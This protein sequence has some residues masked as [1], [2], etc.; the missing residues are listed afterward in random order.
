MKRF[1]ILSVLALLCGAALPVA[2]DEYGPDSYVQDGLII[3]LDGEYNAGR[4]ANGVPLDHDKTLLNWVDLVGNRV[5][6]NMASTT[7]PKVLPWEDKALHFTTSPDRNFKLCFP[8]LTL[9]WSAITFDMCSEE[10]TAKSSGTLFYTETSVGTG[11]FISTGSYFYQFFRPSPYSFLQRKVTAEPYA[12]QFVGIVDGKSFSAYDVREG[13]QSQTPSSATVLGPLAA[14]F[15]VAG[16]SSSA[17]FKGRLHAFRVYERALSKK[18]AA[19]NEAV[20][21]VRYLGDAGNS[22]RVLTDQLPAAYGLTLAPA[23]GTVYANGATVDFGVT[24]LSAHADD[25]MLSREY[26]AGTRAAFYKW[27]AWTGGPSASPHSESVT[28]TTLSGSFTAKT[29]LAGVDWDIRAQH[30]V[31]VS[32]ATGGSVSVDGG[33]AEASFAGWFDEGAVV[34]LVAT[35]AEGF[36]FRRWNGD[37]GSAES[38]DPATITVPITSARKI[39]A[40]FAKP[41]ELVVPDAYGPDS[42]VQDGLIVQLD[43]E[44]NAG[45]NWSGGVLPHDGTL[46]CWMDLVCNRMLTNTVSKTANL[47][48]EDNAL[49]FKAEDNTVKLNFPSLTLDWSAITFDMCCEEDTAKSNGYLFLAKTSLG[50][51]Y[52][53]F[54]GGH[55]FR[56][57]VPSY[58]YLYRSSTAEPYVGQFF[59]VV[60]GKS[61]SAYDVRQGWQHSTPAAPTVL[62]TLT[63]DFFVGGN[64][65]G[66]TKF[67]G[68]YHAFRTY[69]RVLSEKE[70]AWNEAVDKVRYLGVAANSVKVIVD[71]LPAAYG[72]TLTPADGT[73]YTDGTTVDFSVEGLS[74]HADDGVLSREYET[75]SRAAFY[76]WTVWTGGPATS[77]HSEIATGMTLSDSLTAKNL[78]ANV[79]WDIRT[80]HKVDVSASGSG[81]VSVNGG[82]AAASFSGWFDEGSAVTL[83]ATPVAGYEFLYWIGDIGS[84]SSTEPSIV[85]EVSAAR[86]VQAVFSAPHEP[87]RTVWTGGSSTEWDNPAN[88]D[89]GVPQTGDDVVITNQGSARI[90]LSHTTPVFNSLFVQNGKETPD[91]SKTQ[92]LVLTNWT[93]CLRAKTITLG[94]GA[95][96]KPMG[97]CYN[98]TMPSRVWIA[99]ETLTV[100]ETAKIDADLCGYKSKGWQNVPGQGPAWE[101]CASPGSYNVS[102]VYG[103]VSAYLSVPT[104][105]PYGSAAEPEQPGSAGS[106]ANSAAGGAIRLDVTGTLTVDGRITAGA[107]NQYNANS[108]C[109]GGGIWITCDK[110]TGS[111]EICANAVNCSKRTGTATIQGGGGRVAVHYNPASQAA[112]TACNVRIEALT[113]IYTDYGYAK[114]YS[115][116]N[117]QLKSFMYDA[118]DFCEDCIPMMGLGTIWF[119]D[120]TLLKAASY[121]ANGWKFGGRLVTPKPIDD[122]SFA[123]DMTF[124]NCQLFIDQPGLKVDFAGDVDVYG[125]GYYARREMGVIFKGADV[126]VGG[127]LT[128]AGSRFGVRGGSVT[129]NGSV[130]QRK[131]AYA[132]DGGFLGGEIFALAAPTNTPNAYGAALTVNGDWN[133]EDGGVVRVECDQNNGAVVKITANRNM[134]LAEGAS[135]N[136]DCAGW[137]NGPGSGTGSYGAS[138]GG[139]GAGGTYKAKDVYGSEKEPVD[140][141]SGGGNTYSYMYIRGGGAVLLEV[142]GRL[143]LNGIISADSNRAFI[144]PYRSGGSGGSVYIRALSIVGT[145]GKVRACGGHSGIYP[146]GSD[147]K[148][149]GGGGRIAIRVGPTQDA[150]ATL[151]S[152]LEPAVLPGMRI[153]QF[154]NNYKW[155]DSITG[156][157]DAEEGTVFWK[158][159]GGGLAV[160]VK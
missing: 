114:N 16:T 57:P 14:D 38:E 128:V 80:Q 4:D 120:D 60:D 116:E 131:C 155:P 28:G 65:S 56:F 41:D 134:S 106:Q 153:I 85:L 44:Y 146:D 130:T 7:P 138:Y 37:I 40:V 50:N 49:H 21:K 15:Y 72:L 95:V 144:H 3:Q 36:E 5:L 27:T 83:V 107:M 150:L 135:I 11:K 34:T 54:V 64:E 127:D 58:G 149:A 125:T 69:D 119:P 10:D 22:V 82:A 51:P 99:G 115:I 113:S 139:K 140:P 20:D 48:W 143:E 12:G 109:S 123:G 126:T 62:G 18:E 19:W 110:L 102:G 160:I 67:K 156:E 24:G 98:E 145:T 132:Y 61:Y 108:G 31:E 91:A 29:L 89:N 46:K 13:W 100:S 141:G 52:F 101:G 133:V 74:A 1:T 53:S 70:A 6:E 111:G 9:D 75:G 88:W 26:A 158:T 63:A 35:P 84:A 103:G 154:N 92:T 86:Q 152:W 93:T 42:Y 136:S 55:L 96:V 43:G 148:S 118:Y 157:Y 2:A 104:A 66:G 122:L 147:V 124:T 79:V 45:R 105:A 142:A 77:P 30:K 73:V 59:A 8:E 78:L 25:G 81:T 47:P 76:K 94:V 39:Q 23:D 90:I 117:E 159:F 87:V 137:Q 112:E 151:K 121:R 32:A 97:A 129:V 33:E 71:P 17:N 68:K